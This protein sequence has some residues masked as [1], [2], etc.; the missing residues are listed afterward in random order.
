MR[1]LLITYY[2]PPCGGASVQRWLKWL[3]DLVKYGHEVTVLTTQDGEYPYIDESLLAEIPAGVNVL[4]THTPSSGKIWKLVMGE[5]N[6]I[7]Y[8]DLGDRGKSGILRKLMIWARL[9]L[10]IPDLRKV[11][12]SQAYKTAVDHLRK[13]PTDLVITT[14]PPHSTHLIGLKI[15]QRYKLPW[16]ADWR[17]PWTNIYYLKLNPPSGLSMLIHRRLERKVA[18]NTDLNIVVS[19]HLAAQLPGGNTCVI[20]NGFDARKTAAARSLATETKI[21]DTFKLKYVGNL[22][23][24]QQFETLLQVIS[25]ALQGE[26]FELS[27][28]GTRLDQKQKNLLR[29]LI[30]EK[31]SVKEFVPHQEALKEMVGAELLLLL[32]NYYEGSEGMLTT[33]LFEYIASGTKIFC[34]GP[35]GGEAEKIIREYN[36]GAYLDVDEIA[37][38]EAYLR[39]I[40]SEWKRGIDIKNKLDVSSLSS[41]NQ[42]FKLIKKL[43]GLKRG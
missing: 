21:S 11:W 4:R 38:A 29:T 43:E 9:N 33:K 2:F 31:H 37:A 34:L 30:P 12:N 28:V 35:K 32:I 15:K 41:Q 17:D 1:L 20:Y 26:D 25:S 23:E 22:T 39:T 3:P 27:F 7:P 8:G 19:E 6:A 42:V 24:G 5:K 40:L 10:I 13:N 18:L 16:V 14:G 36:S